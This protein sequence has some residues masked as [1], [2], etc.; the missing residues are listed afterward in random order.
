MSPEQP[1]DAHQATDKEPQLNKYFKAAIKTMANDIHLKVGQPPKLRIYGELKNTTGEVLTAERMEQLVFEIM[2][3]AQ[4]EAFLAQGTLDFAHEVG[5]E[6]RFRLNVFRQRGMISLV[7][8]RVSAHVPSFE[9]LNL[10]PILS[11]IAESRQGLVLVVGATG[12]GKTTTIAAMLDYI[13]KTR[14]CHI[15]TIE[16][17]IEY[18]YNDNKAIVSQREIG[19]DVP[20]F[21]DALTYLMRQD[22]DVVFVGEMRDAK[23]VTAGMRAAE[24]GHMVMGTMHSSNASQ[25]V[26]RLLDLF[27]TNERELVRQALA[28]SIR[29]IVSQVLLPSIREGSDRIPAVEVLLATPA[30]RKLISEGREA[31]LPAVIR[32]SQREGMQDLTENLCKLVQDGWIDPKDAYKYAPNVEELKMALKGIR[33]TAEG[34]L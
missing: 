26:H 16:D 14:S 13:T 21:E 9:K 34:I 32:A 23:T 28:T 7:G 6:H 11:K 15:V 20:N 4:K 5:R 17:P 8:R 30:V 31:D 33:T 29:A 18:L 10:P 27:P 3:P 22:P 19:L 2:S 12:C 1:L 24:T 25:A